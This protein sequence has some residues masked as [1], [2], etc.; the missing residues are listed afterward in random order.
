MEPKRRRRLLVT[1]TIALVVAVVGGW[2]LSRSSD[3]I[4]ARLTTPGVTDYPTIATNQDNKG[5]TFRFVP[6]ESLDGSGEVT[7]GPS[8]RPL[9]VNFWFS[10]CEPCKREM[11]ALSE[12]AAL[13][14]G[15][16]DFIGINPND[17]TESAK[18]FL[19]KFNVSYPNYLDDGD[20]LSEA[21]VATMPAT[22]FLDAD[23][24]ILERHAGELTLEDISRTL[25]KVYGL[26]E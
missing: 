19:S 9:V 3:D 8:G 7:L 2:A 18:T 6:V 4:D 11:P 1:L 24:T 26:G 12:A 13:Y 14:E 10:T 15:R 5:E 20:L 22:F 17:S 16:V 21:G 25:V 23:G